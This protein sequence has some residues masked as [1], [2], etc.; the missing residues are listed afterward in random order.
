MDTQRL[1]DRLH[2]VPRRAD[3]G[4]WARWPRYGEV[5]CLYNGKG[6]SRGIVADKSFGG[7]A[8]EVDMAPAFAIG[9]KVAVLY[10]DV[11]LQAS[12]QRIQKGDARRLRFDLEWDAGPGFLENLLNSLF[13]RIRVKT[14]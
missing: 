11:T 3:R 5:V 14:G 4:K 7:I 6:E 12:V 10:G 2:G 8:V 9:E 13:D 1:T